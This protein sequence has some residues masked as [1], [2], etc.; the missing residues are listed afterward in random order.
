MQPSAERV[1]E[2]NSFR[3]EIDKNMSSKDYIVKPG[4]WARSNFRYTRFLAFTKCFESSLISSSLISLELL[5]SR[6]I[7]S[8]L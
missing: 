2:R 7:A 6:Y 5:R 8:K 3:L 1:S 4:Q